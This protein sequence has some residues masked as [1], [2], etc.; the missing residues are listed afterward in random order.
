[1]YFYRYVYVKNIQFK[2]ILQRSNQEI[3]IFAWIYAIDHSK[4]LVAYIS[5]IRK[6]YWA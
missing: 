6:K 1:M 4:K 2:D 3:R 5:I